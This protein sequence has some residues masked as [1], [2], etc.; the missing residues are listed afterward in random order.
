MFRFL[1]E[2]DRY[3]ISD[4]ALATSILED[5][6]WVNSENKKLVFDKYKIRRQRIKS[7]KERKKRK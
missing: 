7:R 1:D 5:I 6:G 4:A 3:C 2:L